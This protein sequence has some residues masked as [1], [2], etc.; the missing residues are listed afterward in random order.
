MHTI[1]AMNDIF[2]NNPGNQNTGNQMPPKLGTARN[3]VFINYCLL[4]GSFFIPLL[5][6][7]VVVIYFLKQEE[8]SDAMLS[9]HLR[10]QIR[11]ITFW[12]I[13][14]IIGYV[15][16]VLLIGQLMI[17]AVW[18]WAIYRVIKGLIYLADNK[19][20]YLFTPNI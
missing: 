8:I 14:V 3:Y 1:C 9:S 5:V 16:W 15:T 6:M 18:L 7:G 12:V 4:V 20:M 2:N 17:G 10:W 19:T 13:W 11:T